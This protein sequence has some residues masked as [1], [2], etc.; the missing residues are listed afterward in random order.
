MQCIKYNFIKF[1]A[2]SLAMSGTL[3]DLHRNGMRKWSSL[4]NLTV[5]RKSAAILSWHLFI[6]L[7]CILA[8]VLAKIILEEISGCDHK[9]TS[10]AC[11][12]YLI[13]LLCFGITPIPSIINCVPNTMHLC[14]HVCVYISYTH[15]DMHIDI[16]M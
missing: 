16:Q 6:L 3:V 10:I 11:E 5:L 14:M 12:E 1:Q 4:D 2:M 15:T 7:K 9:P 8:Q 13:Y